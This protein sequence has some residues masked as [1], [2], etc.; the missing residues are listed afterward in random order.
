[1]ESNEKQPPDLKD[2]DLIEEIDDEELQE[3]VLEAQ[4]EALF[5]AG[6]RKNKPQNETSISK[7]AILA[8]LHCDGF[9]Y[10]CGYF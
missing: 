4:R 7:M 10:I 1:M 9:Q 2:L 8:Y 5:K 6:A 3:L